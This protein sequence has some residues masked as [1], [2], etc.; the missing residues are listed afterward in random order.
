M[1]NHYA[2]FKKILLRILLEKAS[3][4]QRTSCTKNN[5]IPKIKKVYNDKIG[6]KLYFCSLPIVY[7]TFNGVTK[8][9]QANRLIFSYPSFLLLISRHLYGIAS[10]EV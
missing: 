4:R 9:L 6:K 10:K 7:T 8:S 3:L 5:Y 2:N 1:S